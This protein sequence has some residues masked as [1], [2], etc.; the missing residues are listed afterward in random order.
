[1]K[2]HEIIQHIHALDGSLVIE[3]DERSAF[4]PLAWGDAFFYYAPDGVMP[5]RTQPYGTIITK[6]YPDD[7]RSRLN[8]PGRFRVNIHLTRERAAALAAADADPAE[9]DIFVPHPVYGDAG[10]ISVVNPDAR[11]ADSVLE[12]LRDAHEAARARAERRRA[13]S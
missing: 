7:V 2:M 5:E 12:L 9:P 1:M 4:P 6:D 3:P 10:W 11:T 8:G 13:T